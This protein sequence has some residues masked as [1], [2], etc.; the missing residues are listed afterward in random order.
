MVKGHWSW[1]K[2]LMMAPSRPPPRLVLW[3]R[4]PVGKKHVQLKSLKYTVYI[5][6]TPAQIDLLWWR[7]PQELLDCHSPPRLVLLAPPHPR[8]VMKLLGQ[9]IAWCVFSLVF[10]Q[11]Q[12]GEFRFAEHLK[13]LNGLNTVVNLKELDFRPP[14]L[15][16]FNQDWLR[17]T[18]IDRDWLRSTEFVKC[19]YRLAEVDI[20]W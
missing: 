5:Y 4:L 18:D 17:F 8:L 15:A 3:W 16:E 1:P 7:L 20:S 10:V 2:R 13:N 11:G 12:G 6:Y 9:Y 19:L 14:R